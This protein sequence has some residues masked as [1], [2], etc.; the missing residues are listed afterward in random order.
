[1]TNRYCV[2]AVIFRITLSLSSV[3]VTN[4][5]E[6]GHQILDSIKDLVNHED[7]AIVKLNDFLTRTKQ[8]TEIRSIAHFFFLLGKQKSGQFVAYVH[9]DKCK[10]SKRQFPILA[11]YL[12]T[13]RDSKND[14]APVFVSLNI[15]TSPEFR[16]LVGSYGCKGTP[17]FIDFLDR[18]FL[19]SH[20]GI[21]TKYSLRER[22]GQQKAENNTMD[23]IE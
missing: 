1:M 18:T 9:S 22:Y 2:I 3:H 14:T 15:R 10:Y 13:E 12:I 17:C 19:H 23:S 11:D 5:D 20:T 6:E 16:C 21:S 8:L 7:R 4:T